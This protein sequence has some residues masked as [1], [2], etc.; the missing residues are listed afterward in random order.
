MEDNI[1]EI[2]LLGSN[3]SYTMLNHDEIRSKNSNIKFLLNRLEEVG[4]FYIGINIYNQK[5]FK[6]PKSSVAIIYKVEDLKSNNSNKIRVDLFRD[7]NLESIADLDDIL[8]KII[9]RYGTS[10]K[11]IE[12]I[13]ISEKIIEQFAK[14]LSNR[15][16]TKIK[17]INEDGTKNKLFFRG[18]PLISEERDKNEKAVIYLEIKQ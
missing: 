13:S 16:N 5:L 8:E 17:V 7:Y 6:F 11:E 3:Q 4:D 12:S 2:I 18:I 14:Y 1:K 15:L 9:R 10:G